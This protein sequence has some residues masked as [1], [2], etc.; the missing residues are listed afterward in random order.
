M[1]ST[2]K[3][4]FNPSLRSL[5]KTFSSLNFTPFMQKE[6]KKLAFIVEGESKKVSPV[7]TGR[8][9]SSI[10]VDLEPLTA[11]IGPHVRYDYFVHE[12]TRFMAAR[13]FMLW[14]AESAS[15]RFDPIFEKDVKSFI[16]SKIR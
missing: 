12:G 5:Q 14:G 4:T 3:I 1:P 7:D 8:M 6:V 2:I 10:S 11:T 16:S 13:P 15:S 9:R